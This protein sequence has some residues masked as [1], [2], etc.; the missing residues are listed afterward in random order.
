MP[1]FD[2][3]WIIIMFGYL[4]L[5]GERFASLSIGIRRNFSSSSEIMPVII[6]I[7]ILGSA[8]FVVLSGSYAEAEQKWAFGSIGTIVGYWF[9]KVEVKSNWSL[10]RP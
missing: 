10:T 3:P 4:I 1:D 7:A 5:M 9:K 6:S 2:W 8:L